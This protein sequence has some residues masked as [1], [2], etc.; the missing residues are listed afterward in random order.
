MM[1]IDVEPLERRELLSR[2]AALLVV[3]G[4][5]GSLPKDA[6]IA[7]YVNY[8]TSKSLAPNK[9]APE[10][11]DGAYTQLLADA[12]TKPGLTPGKTL[13]FAAYDSRL[14]IA[15]A[16]NKRDGNLDLSGVNFDDRHFQYG[17]Q[18]LQYW[19]DQA[20]AGWIA[21][22]GDTREFRVDIIA[23]SL[24]GILTRAL[25]QSTYYRSHDRGVIDHV[26][27][28]GTP[29]TG[30][31]DTLLVQS[32]DL[33]AYLKQQGGVL[34]QLGAI[35]DKFS[36]GKL[37]VAHY[38]PSLNDLEPTFHAANFKIPANPLLADLN[39]SVR[40]FASSVS[41]VDIVVG[42]GIPTTAFVNSV[43][44]I[45]LTTADGDSLVL[46]TSA[47]IPRLGVEHVFAGADHGAL[48]SNPQVEPV[49]FSYLGEE[50]R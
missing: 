23:H 33:A 19:I 4:L 15:P 5:L 43:H 3:P 27:L 41:S 26:V 30:S 39:A 10:K 29:N 32:L 44:P 28:E 24:G 34:A 16:D 25:V 14:A 8:F 38:A 1:T 17:V 22:Y 6:S 46:T 47:F 49:V 18:Y 13:F 20:R 36:L 7:G 35:A 9:L 31:V 12:A 2:P 21:K 40:K 50:T 42:S 37:N 48:P 45:S 11:L